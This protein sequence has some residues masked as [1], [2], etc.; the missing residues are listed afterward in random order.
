MFLWGKIAIV[1]FDE[2]YNVRPVRFSNDLKAV[3]I[4]NL[5]QIQNINAT[6]C[7][8]FCDRLLPFPPK[9][10]VFRQKHLRLFVER[11][12]TFVTSDFEFRKLTFDRRS[13][14]MWS[15]FSSMHC[16]VVLKS[17]GNIIQIKKSLEF[18]YFWEESNLQLL[19]LSSFCHFLST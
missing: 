6:G 2:S 4:N 12:F 13:E 15:V 14:G 16:F 1:K 11:L 8:H 18:A 17:I 7:V 3:W 5:L 19:L 9:S 10:C